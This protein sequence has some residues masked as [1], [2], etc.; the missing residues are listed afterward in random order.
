MQDASLQGQGAGGLNKGQGAGGLNQQFWQ[1]HNQQ[2]LNIPQA[3]PPANPQ[4][5]L[6]QN[7]QAANILANQNAANQM[8]QAVAQQPQVPQV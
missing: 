1:Q 7:V 5:D 2:Q 3:L 4:L 6:N 8:N